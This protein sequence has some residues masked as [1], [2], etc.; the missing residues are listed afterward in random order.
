MF[1]FN[2]FIIKNKIHFWLANFEMQPIVSNLQTNE[3]KYNNHDIS[4][5]E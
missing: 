1:Y 3:Y 2:T 5:I 4:I